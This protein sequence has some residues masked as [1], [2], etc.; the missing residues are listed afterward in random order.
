M[1]NDKKTQ[2]QLVKTSVGNQYVATYAGVLGDAT[3]YECK[4]PVSGKK[5]G[6]VATVI[7][8]RFGPLCLNYVA[9]A[10]RARNIVDSTVSWWTRLVFQRQK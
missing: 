9:A 7:P 5:V 1:D 8:G 4:D 10:M 2:E 3:Y 6:F